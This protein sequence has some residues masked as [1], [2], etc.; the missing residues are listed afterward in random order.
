MPLPNRRIMI[1]F[2]YPFFRHGYGGGQQIVRGLAGALVR[3]GREVHVVCTGHD[4]IGVAEEDSPVVYHFTGTHHSRVPG[5]HTSRLAYSLA[6]QLRPELLVC[7]TSEAGPL[8][9]LARAIGLRSLVYVAAPRLAPFAAFRT[10]T[11][12]EIRYGLGSFLQFL[13]ARAAELVLTASHSLAVEAREQWRVSPGYVIPVGLGIAESMVATPVVPPPTVEDGLRFLSIGRIAHAQKP[14]DVM[15]DALATLDR[16]WH[17]WTIIGSGADEPQ[18]RARIAELGLGQRV[19]FAGT[20]LGHDARRELD[21][22]HIVLL[23]SRYES[24]FLTVYEAASRGRI[25]V[26]NDVADIRRRFRGVASVLVAESAGVEEYRRELERAID[27]FE[28]L[29]QSA[30]GHSNDVRSTETWDAV[31][32]KLLAAAES[33]KSGKRFPKPMKLGS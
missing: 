3:A 29:S 26:T 30:L 12:R 27:N 2:E 22:A 33:C 16:P 23:P 18:L 24:Y 15:A 11:L 19:E 10:S 20:L 17:K 7:T 31:A 4:E 14:L 8:I 25:V 9:P 28:V 13:G 32:A 6:R 21:Q 1:T 5:Y